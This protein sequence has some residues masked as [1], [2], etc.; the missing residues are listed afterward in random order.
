MHIY[1]THIYYISLFLRRKKFLFRYLRRMRK[2][3]SDMEF[4]K[5]LSC[6]LM[7]IATISFV[8]GHMSENNKLPKHYNIEFTLYN[9]KNIFYGEYNVSIYFPYEARDIYLYTENLNIIEITIT[10]EMFKEN[11]REIFTYKS[12]VFF[13]YTETYITFISVPYNIHNFLGQ[14]NL[15]I[16][17]KG[18]LV[19]NGGFRTLYMN[20][21]NSKM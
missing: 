9:D 18:S 17:F 6:S 10:N 12:N 11:K 3:K 8:D 16:K 5:V 1:I 19:E 15:N 7:F 21:Q 2:K 13:V 4:L 14:Y 20:Q